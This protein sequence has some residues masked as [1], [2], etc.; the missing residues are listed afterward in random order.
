MPDL[1]EIDDLTML[2]GGDLRAVFGQIPVEQ[3]IAALS[4]TT[5]GLRRQ[6]LMKLPRETS[7]RLDLAL[8]LA[9][10]VSA[11]E[12]RQAQRALLNALCRLSRAGAIAFDL[13]EDMV[14]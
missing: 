14:A 13:P 1:L 9:G 7:A 2:D 5:P 12:A 8:N 3:L 11:I 4:A 6:L 10:P